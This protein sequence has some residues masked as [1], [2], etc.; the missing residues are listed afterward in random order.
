LLPLMRPFMKTTAQGAAT[1]IHLAS[2]PLEE[3]VT[4]LYFSNSKPKKSS[5][6]SY[7]NAAARRLWQVSTDL[8]GL[9]AADSVPTRRAH[10]R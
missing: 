10:E 6:S 7:D 8:I 1:S 2:S 9:T 5:K 4:G 3:G